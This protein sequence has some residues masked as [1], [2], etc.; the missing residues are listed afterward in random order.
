MKDIFFVPHLIIKGQEGPNDGLVSVE[1]AKWGEYKGT[2][3]ADHYD[4]VGYK[5]LDL[6]SPFKLLEFLDD[7]FSGLAAKGF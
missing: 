5:L 7:V 4:V 2:L 1:S 3:D 6:K